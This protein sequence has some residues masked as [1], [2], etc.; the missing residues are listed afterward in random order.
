MTSSG[1]TKLQKIEKYK[2]A[3]VRSYIILMAI[4]L[5]IFAGIFTFFILDKTMSWYLYGGLFFLLYSYFII[6]KRYS[7]NILVHSYMIIASFY[8]FYIMLAFWH[9]SVASFVWLMPIPL[10]AYVFFSRKYV[11]LYSLFVL[12]NIAAGYLISVNFDFD[13]KE[14]SREDVKLT[15]TFLVISNVAVIALLIYYKDKI[16]REEIYHQIENVPNT[17][18]RTGNV[19]E[20]DPPFAD[21]LFEKI[22]SAM[23]DQQ[24]YKDVTFNISKLSAALGVNNSYISKAIRHNGYPNFNSYLNRYRVNCVKK[25]LVENDLEKVT[26]MSIYTEAGFSNQSTFNRVFK[27]LEKITPSDMIRQLNNDYSS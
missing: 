15:D 17:E 19:A 13:F 16:R 8:N 4:V 27:Q 6:G 21:E 1:L 22:E 10:A 26:L 3:L 24:F 12:L 18:T 11:I 7:V 14:H 25:L 5:F 20:K 23:Q 2:K 9:N